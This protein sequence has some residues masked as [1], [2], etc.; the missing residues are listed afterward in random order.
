MA[1]PVDTEPAAVPLALPGP[2][3]SDGG[4]SVVMSGPVMDIPLADEPA[5]FAFDSP[6]P[7]PSARPPSNIADP[8]GPPPLEGRGVGAGPAVDIT[9]PSLA[10]RTAASAQGVSSQSAWVDPA[11]L[12]AAASGPAFQPSELPP[13]KLPPPPPIGLGP[14]ALEP[15]SLAATIGS[16]ELPPPPPPVPP[17]RPFL[18]IAAAPQHI[19]TGPDVA[20]GPHDLCSLSGGSGTV[21]LWMHLPHD[22]VIADLPWGRPVDPLDATLY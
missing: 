22:D 1:N 9:E 16:A 12:A 5:L 11:R 21:P 8:P 10:V 18:A 13:R 4:G 17:P 14:W 15:P 20:P 6:P 3:A 7:P 2:A 19:W